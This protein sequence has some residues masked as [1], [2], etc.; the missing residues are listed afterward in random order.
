MECC[1]H[2]GK[3]H[4]KPRGST[5]RFSVPLLA[6]LMISRTVIAIIRTG[7]AISRTLIVIS[8]THIAITRILIAMSRTGPQPGDQRMA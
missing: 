7:I 2:V 8:R 6:A 1:G 5:S 3:Q 4:L